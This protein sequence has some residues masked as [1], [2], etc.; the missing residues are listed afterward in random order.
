MSTREL[1]RS[2]ARKLYEKFSA[3][4]RRD[5]RA[6]GLYGKPRSPKRP[7]FHQWYEMHG[8]DIGQMRESTPQDVREYLELPA[9]QDPWAEASSSREP[10]AKEERGVVTMNIAGAEED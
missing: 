3:Q 1:N 7:T 10:E 2:I 6:Q 4:W 5:L 8:R 9:E